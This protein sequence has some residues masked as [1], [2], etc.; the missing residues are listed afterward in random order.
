VA[1]TRIYDALDAAAEAALVLVSAPAGSGKSM[2][3]SGWLAHRGGGAWYSLDGEDNDPALFWP[4]VATALELP[5]PLEVRDARTVARALFDGP[6][7]PTVLALDDYHAITNTAVHAGVDQLLLEAPAHLRLVIATRHDPPLMLSR[8]RAQGSLRELRFD[9]LRFDDGEIDALLREATGLQLDSD[10][11]QRLAQRTDGWA[12][13]VQLVGLSLHNHDDPGA[14]VD[15]FS[16]DNRH[17]ADY[18]RDEVLT[19][20][21]DRLRAFLLGTAVLDRL[22]APLCEAV[23]GAE[24]A[25]QLLEELERLNLFVLPL[26]ARRRWFRYHHLFADWLRLQARPNPS[27][28][29]A[30]ADWLLAKGHTGDAVRHLLAAGEAERA[31]DVIED[32]RWVL[33]GRGREETLRERVQLLPPD[34]LRRRPGL[35]LAA[36]WVA[37]HGGRWHDVQRLAASLRTQDLDELTQAEVLLLEAGRSVA[38]GEFTEALQT[39]RAG[40]ELVDPAEPRARTGLLLVQGRSL[41]AQG[42][43]DGAAASFADAASLA[44]P[45]DV[46]IVLLI[47]RS[48]LAEI[49]RRSGR[50]AEAEAEA[51]AALELAESSG[52]AEHP[53]ASVA[54][55]TLADVLLDQGRDG[56]A[57]PFAARG[58]ELSRRVPYVPREQQAAAVEER[59][60]ATRSRR[61]GP[62]MVESLTGRELSVLRLLPSSLTPRE[63]ASELYLSINTIK[64]H[65]RS[66]YRKL[67]VQ[68]RHEA[69]EEARRQQLL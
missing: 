22:T 1:R 61:R 42:D 54:N 59:F 51:R 66:L 46:T 13:A 37:H 45:F 12:A 50:A 7:A 55:L 5:H 44:T 25:Q 69:I 38:V 47:A 9:D 29:L 30:A 16:G 2:A 34:V 52:L 33:V 14:V 11:L 35:T 17:V 28:H 20:L 60:T 65:T 3:L 53:E 15:A 6:P 48:H 40:L 24:D 19:R 63:I 8:L 26:D 32:D 43:L 18:L 4:S 27:Q 64:T 57:A 49:H 58:L 10:D 21:P 23:T 67:G 31:A 68:T 56:E 41:L 39:A 62:G 36:A